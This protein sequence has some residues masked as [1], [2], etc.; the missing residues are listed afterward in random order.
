MADQWIA[1]GEIRTLCKHFDSV[2]GNTLL[3]CKKIICKIAGNT[4]EEFNEIVRKST[5]IFLKACKKCKC[6]E[7]VDYANLPSSG[8]LFLGH[9]DPPVKS[10][11]QIKF[12][13]NFPIE[14]TM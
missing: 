7:Q 9:Q 4:L 8:A 13:A 2:Q 1:A 11:D 3:E 10:Y 6:A 14:I 12:L 5:K